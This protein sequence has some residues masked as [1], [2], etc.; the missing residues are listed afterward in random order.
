MPRPEISTET[1]GLINEIVNQKSDFSASEL[2]T[3]SKIRFCLN[4][5]KKKYNQGVGGIPLR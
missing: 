4:E 2:S 5:L 1:L 3:D